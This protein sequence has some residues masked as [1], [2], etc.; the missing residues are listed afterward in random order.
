MTVGVSTHT[1]VSETYLLKVSVSDIKANLTEKNRTCPADKLLAFQE[2]KD[3]FLKIIVCKQGN[4][5]QKVF[6]MT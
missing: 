4:H 1:A 6:Y 5:F 3:I 2:K